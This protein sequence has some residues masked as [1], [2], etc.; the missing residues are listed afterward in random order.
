MAKQKINELSAVSRFVE[1]F[2]DGLADNTGDRIIKQAKK[3]R[4]EQEAIT[5][6][7]EI[8]RK[9]KELEKILNMM[10]LP[11]DF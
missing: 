10:P 1:R 6:M 11:K 4:M 2:F 5:K 9:K 7:E 3:R 8:V